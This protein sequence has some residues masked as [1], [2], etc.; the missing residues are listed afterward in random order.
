V[1]CP[2]VDVSEFESD[3][4][5]LFLASIIMSNPRAMAI[6]G[7]IE[8]IHKHMTTL[9]NDTDDSASLE[10]WAKRFVEILVRAFFV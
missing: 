7:L 1:F 10:A 3:N 4:H 6:K 9:P 8:R 2:I 5:L